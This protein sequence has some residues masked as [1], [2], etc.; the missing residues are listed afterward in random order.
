M[1]IGVIILCRHDSS[2]LPGKIL[3]EIRGK[4]ILQ[5]IYERVQKSTLP[6]SIVVAT[7]IE[8]SDDPIDKYCQEHNIQVF[9]GSKNNVAQR[10]LDCAAKYDFGYCVRINGDNLF[11]DPD[12][13]S[14]MI[15]MTETSRYDFISNVKGRTFPRGMSIEI[16][17]RAFFELAVRDFDKLEYF[18]HVTLFFY[19]HEQYGR[20]LHITNQDC[21]QVAGTNLAIDT[22]DDFNYAELL[23]SKMTSDHTHYLLKDIVELMDASKS[24]IT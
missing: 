10:F 12:L 13:L 22:Q 5:Y 1:T 16:V 15:A 18:E 17:R 3:R 11:V 6:E 20:Q 24:F 9:R 14:K 8:A 23:I 21:P 2:R 19:E 7:S 4:P